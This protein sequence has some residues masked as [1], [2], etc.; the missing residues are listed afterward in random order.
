MQSPI[1]GPKK[2]NLTLSLCL[3]KSKVEQAPQEEC[4]ISVT[5]SL[6]FPANATDISGSFDLKTPSCFLKNSFR[7]PILD[8]VVSGQNDFPLQKLNVKV[9][10]QIVLTS[11][12]LITLSNSSRSKLFFKSGFGIP[13]DRDVCMYRI[14]QLSAPIDSRV[15]SKDL[16]D[17]HVPFLVKI[18]SIV[19]RNPVI[20]CRF[21]ICAVSSQETAHSVSDALK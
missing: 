19:H 16:L 1:L 2:R 7:T 12:L 4:P 11:S 10:I 14:S 6:S 17:T 13:K 18:Y 5:S 8:G 3:S 20:L 9:G 15:S 21:Y